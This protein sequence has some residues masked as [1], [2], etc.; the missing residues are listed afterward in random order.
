MTTQGEFTRFSVRQRIEH[1]SVMVLFLLLAI[2]GFPQKF[3][4]T[5]WAHTV[6]AAMGGIE[7]ARLIHRIS[8]ILFSVFTVFHLAMASIAVA[9]GRAR[10]TMI[11]SRKD[12]VDAV[13]TLKYYMGTSDVHPRFDRFDYKQK[14]EYW[15]LVLGGF[16]MIVTGFILYFPV[17]FTNFLP[18]EFIPASKVAHSN[19]GLMAFLVVITWHIYN[20]H[21]A[22]EVFPFDK[23]IFTGKVSMARM[24]HEHPIE[25][26]FAGAHEAGAPAEN[27]GA[28]SGETAEATPAEARPE[29]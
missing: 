2:T 25:L 23:S 18:G 27:V 19:E 12:F 8:G 13:Q 22:P 6:V 17:F 26:E 21:L 1:F 29:D 14:F 3:Y 4:D 20:A 28:A 5:G 15:G 10:P 9:T 11:P 16:L 7:N 24:H